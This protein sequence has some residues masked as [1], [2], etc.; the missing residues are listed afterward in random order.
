MT[1][2]PCIL[3][4]LF[5][6]NLDKMDYVECS[7]GFVGHDVD[8]ECFMTGAPLWIPA[9]AGMTKKDQS[10]RSHGF[11]L[12][13]QNAPRH[14]RE[15]GNPLGITVI[16]MGVLFLESTESSMP[17]SIFSGAS[18]YQHQR[19]LFKETVG[20]F[21]ESFAKGKEHLLPKFARVIKQ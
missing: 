11:P 5:L 15:G 1:V 21:V 4:P 18:I 19:E 12:F 10:P 7:V 13:S 14:S 16:H 20:T 3:S 17:G 9:F 2:L 6:T 8:R